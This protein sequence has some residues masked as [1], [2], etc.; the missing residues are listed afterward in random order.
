MA[1]GQADVGD[2]FHRLR[3]RGDISKFFCW[4]G[5]YAEEVGVAEVDGVAVEPYAWIWPAH[6]EPTNGL[7]MGLVS[8]PTLQ[9][10][11]AV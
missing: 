4:P 9:F 11:Q 8:G 6:G 7:P 1:L 10:N 3:W 2:C 5:V